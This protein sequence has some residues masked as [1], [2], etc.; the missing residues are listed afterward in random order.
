M[1]AARPV[2]AARVVST[3][4]G[5]RIARWWVNA[6]CIQYSLLFDERRTLSAACM[7]NTIATVRPVACPRFGGPAAARGRRPGADE[8]TQILKQGGET[9]ISAA[10]RA[11]G[12]S[13]CR[14]TIYCSSLPCVDLPA[15]TRPGQTRE[16]ILQPY[17]GRRRR[18]LR[19]RATIPRRAGATTALSFELARCSAAHDPSQGLETIAYAGAC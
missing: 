19:S 11:R 17:A 18:H 4:R 6:S 16:G 1:A 13:T 2:C 14:I 12:P 5:A 7:V 15:G 9:A 3:R 8:L 10:P